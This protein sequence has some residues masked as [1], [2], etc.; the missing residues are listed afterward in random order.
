M[1]IFELVTRQK[2]AFRNGINRDAGTRKEHLNRLRRLI[3]D[4]EKE[5]CDAILKDFG[6]P[7][8]D[9]YVTEVYVVLQEIDFHLKNLD[10]WMKP[11]GVSNILPT[12]PSKSYI[13]KQPF[14]AALVIAPWNYPFHLAMMPVIGALSA[15]NTIVL[16]PSEI[17]SNTS[18][19]IKKLLGSAFSDDLFAVVEGDADTA[20]ELLKQPFDKIFFTGSAHVGKLVMKAAAEQLIPVTLELGGKS[21]AIV[22]KDANVDVAARRIWWGKTINAG[23]TC[24]APDFVLIHENLADAFV[25]ES[26]KALDLFFNGGIKKGENY[27]GIIN[28]KHFDRLKKLLDGCDILLGGRSTPEELL[29]EP[30]LVRAGWGDEIMQDEIFGPILPMVTYSDEQAIIEKL[31]ERPAPL[32]LY[33][34]TE[35]QEFQKR[36]V[37]EVP[38]GGGC[39]N[40]TMVHLGNPNLPFGGT[41]QSGMGSYHGKYSFE[42][43]SRKQSIL[44]KPF[45]PD[46]DLRYPPYDETKLTWFKRLFS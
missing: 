4:H 33:L 31:Q 17:S 24:V 46:P 5:F 18:S 38:F 14:G 13:N 45:W 8:A 40:D 28:K 22:H 15:G 2:K 11:E 12:F 39:F 23:Q 32:A 6:K 19:L 30:A 27:S 25:D 21:P 42:T 41:G 43:F 3:A 7:Y 1:S 34:F 35:D 16:K 37:D 9:A 36:I 10:S 29:I 26:K 20:R 44:K